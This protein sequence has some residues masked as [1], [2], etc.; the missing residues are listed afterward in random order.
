[1]KVELRITIESKNE[2]VIAEMNELVKMVKNGEIQRGFAKG[3][4]C[5][6]YKNARVKATVDVTY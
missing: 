6:K 1:M 2:K 3:S 4:A 5:D